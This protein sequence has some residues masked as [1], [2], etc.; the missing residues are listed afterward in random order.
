MSPAEQLTPAFQ[1]P[2]APFP[3]H[4]PAFQERHMKRCPQC[5]F[6]YED[7]QSLCDMDGVLLVFDSRTLPNLH[8]LAT[9]EGPM[10]GK[11]QRRSLMVPAFATVLLM[12]VLGSVYFVSTQRPAAPPIS[13]LPAS[14]TTPTFEAPAPAPTPS[15]EEAVP[16]PTPEAKEAKPATKQLPAKPEQKSTP[17]PPTPATPAKKK[18]DSKVGSILKKTGRIL[19]KPFKF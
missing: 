9:V 13:D 7:D 1:N 6:I 5:E 17:T 3:I 16:A 11:A 15:V 14:V 10:P 4:Q 12:L 19:K 2:Q 18:D 8:A